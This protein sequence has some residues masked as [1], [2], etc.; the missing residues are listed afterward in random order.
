MKTAI[1]FLALIFL[2]NILFM[3][4]DVD[5]IFKAFNVDPILHFSGGFF[6]AM[7]FAGYLKHLK[8]GNPGSPRLK[9]VLILVSI[10]VFIG[11]IWEFSEYLGTKLFGDYFYNKYRV[12]CC[13]GNLDDTINDLLMDILGAAL[14]V[15]VFL[16]PLRGLDS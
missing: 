14:F 7:F 1:L 8:I 15:F 4:A 3:V 16:N 6:V 10:T 11:V 9:K 2:I 12:I 5:Y 13:M